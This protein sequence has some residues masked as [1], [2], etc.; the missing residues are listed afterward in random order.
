[1][2]SGALTADEIAT[3]FRAI[4]SIKGSAGSFGFSAVTESAHGM[5]SYLDE[6]RSGRRQP[7]HEAV[8]VLLRS[9]VRGLAS[10]T[11]FFVANGVLLPV[12]DPVVAFAS[13]L[14]IALG[15]QAVVLKLGVGLPR[16]PVQQLAPDV[17]P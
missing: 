10:F 7:N 17:S 13:A 16:Q 12:V 11:S 8:A 5:E 15:V 2:D 1:M 4:H 9:L 3:L 6:V 14:G